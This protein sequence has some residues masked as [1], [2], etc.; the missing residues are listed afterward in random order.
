[1]RCY[2]YVMEQNLPENLLFDYENGVIIQGLSEHVY[3]FNRVI[4]HLKVS[5]DKFFTQ[6]YSVYHDMCLNQKKIST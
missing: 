1:M 4:P 2:A 5:E 3:K 6:E